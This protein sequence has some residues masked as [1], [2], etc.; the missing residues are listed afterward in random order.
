MKNKT[1][2]AIYE[3]A[4]EHWKSNKGKGTFIIPKILEDKLVILLILVRMYI[5]NPTFRVL[6]IVETFDD[7][8]D[9]TNFLC[10]NKDFEEQSNEFNDL[11][12]NGFIII[13]TEK[14]INSKGFKE[15]IDVCFYYHPKKLN[16]NIY[17]ILYNTKFILVILNNSIISPDISS[18]I[19]KITPFIDEFKHSEIEKIRISS[20]VEEVQIGIDIPENS[21]EA[22]YIKFANE[23][24]TTSITIFGSFDVINEANSGNYRLNISATQIC[25]QIA[26]QNGWHEHLDM[27]EDFNKDLDNLYNPNA[28]KVRA[29]NTYEI[30]RKRSNILTDY[31][32]KLDSILNIVDNNQDKNILIISKRGE[33]ANE[34]TDFLNDKY[35]DKVCYNYH[36]KVNPIPAIDFEGN[37]ICF[38]TGKNKGKQKTLGV[39]AQKTLAEVLFNKGEI[40]IL[41][42]NNSPDKNLCIDVDVVII[43]SPLCEDMKSYLYRLSS[44]NFR[45]SPII[46]YTLYCKNSLEAKKIERRN[47]YSNHIIKKDDYGEDYSQYTIV[48]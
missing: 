42:T 20:P 41:S 36:D 44:V 48:D 27:S 33:F 5:K 29:S 9:I 22:N 24:I 23:Y 25:K 31:K 16:N 45:S 46:L 19:Y 14:Y 35:N 26:Y 10:H 8:N 11:F 38:K 3:S 6:I 7:I 43:T 37:P 28:I 2:E 39:D 40:N 17:D 34:I 15:H 1:I 30:I 13:L 4:L 47:E 32:G 18:K 21:D 12:N